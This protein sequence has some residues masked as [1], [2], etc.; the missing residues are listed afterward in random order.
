M[1][2][3]IKYRQGLGR[4]SDTD[5]YQ[6]RF[7]HKGKIYTGS[8]GCF[9][10][11]PAKKWLLKYKTEL[12]LNHVDLKATESKK[13]I[14]DVL[15]EWSKYATDTKKNASYIKNLKQRVNDHLISV[16][17]DKLIRQITDADLKKVAQEYLTK[18][19]AKWKHLRRTAS[20]CNNLFMHLSALLSYAKDEGYLAATPKIPWQEEQEKEKKIVTKDKLTEFMKAVDEENEDHFSIIMRFLLYS[21]LRESEARSIKWSQINLQDG[22]FRIGTVDNPQK[23]KKAS[24][25]QLPASLIPLL[26]KEQQKKI[27]S[28]YVVGADTKEGF[29]SRNYLVTHLD[30]V[31]MKVLGF[32]LTTHRMRA[33]F[34][35][36]CST[37]GIDPFTLMEIA[38]HSQ[39][40]TTQRYV[41]KNPDEQKRAVSIMERLSGE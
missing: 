41:V 6:Y 5:A 22:T 15:E 27:Q 38:R 17:G 14:S 25:L 12:S 33:S 36:N 19:N 37:E 11:E 2:Q 1:F 18:P 21:G 26:K 9:E 23:N 40:T 13:K 29:R 34:L 39:V 4:A 35:T 20:G 32:R 30:K 3:P 16:I 7:M 24:I 31:S 10:F 28:I 8:T